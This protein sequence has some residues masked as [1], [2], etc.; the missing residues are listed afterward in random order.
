MNQQ[1]SKGRYNILV[2]VLYPATGNREIHL[3]TKLRILTAADQYRILHSQTDPV[4]VFIT[5]RAVDRNGKIIAELFDLAELAKKYYIRDEHLHQIRGGNIEFT[6]NKVFTG[7]QDL[8]IDNATIIVIVGTSQIHRARSTFN[9]VFGNSRTSIKF[10]VISEWNYV[11]KGKVG[12]FDYMKVLI[13]ELL[14]TYTFKIFLKSV[15]EDL[16][17][18]LDHMPRKHFPS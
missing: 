12:V 13:R 5:G 17:E 1:N 18:F 9:R 4:E 16:K 3:F 2:P 8:N 6:A 11:F 10:L 15:E 7:L 14:Q